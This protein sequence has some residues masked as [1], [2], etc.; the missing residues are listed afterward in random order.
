MIDDRIRHLFTEWF[1]IKRSCI[2]TEF[3]FGCYKAPFTLFKKVEN[4]NPES[5]AYVIRKHSRVVYLLKIEN[6]PCF[7]RS[8]R[9]LAEFFYDPYSPFDKFHVRFGKDSLVIVKI[10]FHTYPD[11]GCT[12]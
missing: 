6:F 11:A 8:R 1:A 4:I 7:C 5:L 9:F 10:V 12:K 3:V 2:T